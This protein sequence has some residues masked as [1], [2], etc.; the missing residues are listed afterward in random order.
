MNDFLNGRRNFPDAKREAIAEF[1]GTTH[2]DML[3]L[4]RHLSKGRSVAR[5]DAAGAVE[6]WHPNA[7]TPVYPDSGRPD[8]GDVVRLSDVRNGYPS[9][10]DPG[11]REIPGKTESEDGERRLADLDPTIRKMVKMLE[12]LEEADRKAVFGTAE[13]RLAAKRLREKVD[14]LREIVQGKK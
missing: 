13:E 14:L 12:Q 5:A 11:G 8:P 4:G 10:P 2:I 7:A 6:D 9:G 1:L 3:V